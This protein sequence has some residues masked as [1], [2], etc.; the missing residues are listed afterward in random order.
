MMFDLNDI[1][2]AIGDVRPLA[3]KGL[4][5]DKGNVSSPA[6][7]KAATSDQIAFCH[8]KDAPSRISNS[9]AGVII[10]PIELK[11]EPSLPMNKV[12]IF[13]EDPRL[14]FVRILRKLFPVAPP[15]ITLGKDVIIHPNVVLGVEGNGWVREED[16]T[17]IRFPAF[18]GVR[19]GNDVEICAGSVIQ[20]GIFE[21]TVIGDNTKIGMMVMIAHNAQIGKSCTIGGCSGI[22]GGVVLED[23]V[24][25][26]VGV[27]TQGY[28]HIGEGALLG[29]GAVA[30]KDIGPGR[31]AYGVPAREVRDRTKEEMAW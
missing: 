24:W 10:C 14:I 29:N 15:K 22:S 3:A 5:C 7:L 16:G 30:T 23:S 8:G 21:D 31:V 26:G 12:L 13:V 2:K 4:S 25:T 6:D 17:R 9:G 20:R 18:A 11:G 19:I 27:M 28:V 1:I